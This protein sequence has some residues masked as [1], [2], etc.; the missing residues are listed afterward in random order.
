M[1]TRGCLVSALAV[2]LLV[3]FGLYCYRVNLSHLIHSYLDPKPQYNIILIINDQEAYRLAVAGDYKLP[4]REE[5]ARHGVT[6]SHH[7]I[8]AAMCSPSRATLLTGVPPQIH[9]IFDQEEYSYV[10]VLAPTRPNMGSVLKQLGYTT[11]YF[12]K[13]E[14]DKKLLFTSKTEG[15]ST[16]AQSYGFD[17]FNYDGDVG[18]E[19]QQGYTHDP[20]FVGEAIRWLRK[21]VKANEQRPFFL[22]ISLLNPH[23]I[24]YGD[25][26]LPNTVQ[27]QQ[28]QSHVILPPPMNTLYQKT[29]QFDLPASLNE[30]LVAKGMPD[31]LNQYQQGWSTA[32]GFIPPDRKDM[33]HFYYNYY[34]N[35]IRD[36]DHNLQ[37][38]IDALNQMHL[39]KNTIVIFTADHGEMGGAHGGLRGKGPMAY[40]ENAHVPLIIAHPEAPHGARCAAIT[41]HLDMLPTLVGLTRSP[42]SSVEQVNRQFPGHDFSRLIL[43]PLGAN[44]HAIRKGVLFNY[45]GIS[46]IDGQYLLTTLVSSF[47]H[48]PLPPLSQVNLSKRGFLS[49]VFDG[50]YKFARFYAPNKINTPLTIEEILQNNDVQL[51]DLQEDPLEMNNLALQYEKNKQL[52]LQMNTLLNA[53]ME[54]EVGP[55]SLAFLPITNH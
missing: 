39:W 25:A 16:Q 53:L 20:Y 30:S 44:V 21:Y 8:A 31:A 9:G 14:M 6:F 48:K 24:M 29:W 54:Q 50:R 41:S 19:P 23:D 26:N 2:L 43:R 7:Y 32:L 36:N 18:G 3:F 45:I 1:S 35:A 42:A 51:F 12:G 33:W 4:A 38:V 13:F 27:A 52:I 46:T 49:F 17:S 40:E 11:A 28:A 34:L 47:S 15:Y 10:P 37:Q 5:L 55:S 22:V